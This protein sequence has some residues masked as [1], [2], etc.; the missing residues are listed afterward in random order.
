ML[1]LKTAI[2]AFLIWAPIFSYAETINMPSWK[3]PLVH[4]EKKFALFWTPRCGCTTIKWWFSTLLGHNK[5]EILNG[6]GNIHLFYSR[7]LSKNPDIPLVLSYPEQFTKIAVVRNPYERIIS[8]FRWAV[9]TPNDFSKRMMAKYKLQSKEEL[10]D[11]V[12]F[13]DFVRFLEGENIFGYY[14]NPHWGGQT[15]PSYWKLIDHVIHL[16]DFE[17]ELS[18]VCGL[19]GVDPENP[20]LHAKCNARRRTDKDFDST[21]ETLTWSQLIELFKNQDGVPTWPHYKFFMPPTVKARVDKI[22]KRDIQLLGYEY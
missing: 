5:Q 20:Y 4:S 16:E 14:T 19:L 22:Y 1:R 15:D 12:T 13:L 7:V 21:L 2:L 8:S 3:Y 18:Q 6:Y 17:E 11:R 10:L 9:G